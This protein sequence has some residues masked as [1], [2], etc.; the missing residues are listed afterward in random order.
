MLRTIFFAACV[1]VMSTTNA[2]NLE[3]VDGGLQQQF[4][5]SDLDE[6]D[7]AKNTTNEQAAAKSDANSTK[8]EV[9]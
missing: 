9:S 4:A 2:V 8:K 7:K 1:A 6:G 3:E 5:Q